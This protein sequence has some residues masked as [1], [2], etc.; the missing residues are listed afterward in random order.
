MGSSDDLFPL[1]GLREREIFGG[2]RKSGGVL[3][4]LNREVRGRS[5]LSPFFWA[6]LLNLT[7]IRT[8]GN[9]TLWSID[10]GFQPRIL[11][12]GS[13]VGER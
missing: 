13:Q 11:G 10:T 1:N 9:M 7:S 3:K 6:A 5:Q 8:S 2:G 12:T 4:G